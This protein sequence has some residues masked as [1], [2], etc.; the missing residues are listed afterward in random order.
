VRGAKRSLALSEG[1]ELSAQLDREAA[2]QAICYESADLLEGL[3]AVREK[4]APR[5]GGG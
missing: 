1:A 3:A 5:F 2:E 4:R